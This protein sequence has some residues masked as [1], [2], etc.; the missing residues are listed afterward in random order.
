MVKIT[1]Q[2]AKDDADIGKRTLA[3]RIGALPEEQDMWGPETFF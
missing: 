3:A 1:E 2:L